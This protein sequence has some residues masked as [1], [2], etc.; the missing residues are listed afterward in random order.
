MTRFVW[1]FASCVADGRK[2]RGGMRFSIFPSK[3]ID[4]TQ[5]RHGEA[6]GGRGY[7]ASRW[8]MTLSLMQVLRYHGQESKVM[9]LRGRGRRDDCCRISRLQQ[10]GA[11]RQDA[12]PRAAARRTYS[13]RGVVIACFSSASASLASLPCVCSILYLAAPWARMPHF[14]IHDATAIMRNY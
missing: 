9:M 6:R 11:S 4:D 7:D 1:A 5:R 14:Q 3:P 12:G 10:M 2:S 8:V 13:R